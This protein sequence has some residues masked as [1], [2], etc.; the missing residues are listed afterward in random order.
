[1]LP[2]Q[3]EMDDIAKQIYQSFDL[4]PHLRS[5][6]LVLCG[7]HGMN[8]GG[9]HGGSAPGETS[10]A[11][12]FAS[13]KLKAISTHFPCPTEPFED[14]HYYDA[15]EQSD[16]VPTLAGLLGIATPLNNLG[17]FLP[18][19]LSL[20]PSGKYA[21]NLVWV[22][23]TNARAEDDRVQLLLR[24]ALQMLRI[25]KA[26]FPHP[27]YNDRSIR[28]DCSKNLS[29]AD[30]LLCSWRRVQD[31]LTKGSASTWSMNDAAPPLTDASSVQRN[32]PGTFKLTILQFCR[33]A[34]RS[35]SSIA[36][37]YKASRLYLGVIAG[38]AA[39]ILSTYDIWYSAIR[40]LQ[41]RTTAVVLSASAYAS[42]MFAS[43]YVEEEHQFWYWLTA[44]WLTVQCITL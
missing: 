21:Q 28:I 39:I 1:M 16:V 33:K 14:Y 3:R 25:V 20:W 34:Q 5:S 36:S 2:K 22:E 12:V 11:L 37:N 29:T 26:S 27:A 24:N 19:F 17:V 13:P 35:L 32:E 4:E 38:L 31:V 6:L 15:V 30:D 43:S 18:R 41:S 40:G 23:G 8:E 44:G 7:D 10:P 9:N 42:M